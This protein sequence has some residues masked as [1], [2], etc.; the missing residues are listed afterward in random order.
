MKPKV[1]FFDFTGCEGCQLA[2]VNLEKEML[3]LVGLIDIVNFREAISDKGQDY[4]VACIEGAISTPTC[5]DRINEIRSKAKVLIT[6]GS[7]SSL[8]GIN[9]MRNDKPMDDI[10]R[11]VYGDKLYWYPSIPALPVSAV[12]KVDY[13]I[14]GCPL[15][16]D[17]FIRV[18]SAILL[19]KT[20]A[21]PKD[22]VCTECKRKENVCVYELGQFCMG[23]VTR[24]GCGARC[25][26]YQHY[27]YGCRGLVPEPNANAEKTVLQD[28][29]LSVPEVLKKFSLFDNAM[30]GWK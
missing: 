6:I 28:H 15:D 19:G 14:P 18:L 30:E 3:D 26:T 7:C 20:P 12:V 9:A 16:E 17:E 27:C 8:G 1:G 29:G 11:A 13:S 24:A 23:P 4:D 22:P 21:I 2:I 25:P 10:R 5:V